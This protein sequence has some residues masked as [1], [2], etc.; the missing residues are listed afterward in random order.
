MGESFLAGTEYMDSTQ[1]EKT[2][3]EGL[4]TLKG[5]RWQATLKNDDITV[6]VQAELTIDQIVRRENRIETGHLTL[7]DVYYE[8]KNDAGICI[9]FPLV[10][11]RRIEKFQRSRNY[12]FDTYWWMFRII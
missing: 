8:I 5:P 1:K 2:L 6:L 10:Q 3:R 4:E 11:F 7:D 12:Y 9:Y